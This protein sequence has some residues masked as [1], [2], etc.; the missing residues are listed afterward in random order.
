MAEMDGNL[1]TTD[2]DAGYSEST[3]M[4]YNVKYFD[5]ENWHF[6]SDGNVAQFGIYDSTHT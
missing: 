6:C 5:G 1:Y 3:A 2:Y 4:N